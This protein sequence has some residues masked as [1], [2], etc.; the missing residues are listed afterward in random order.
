MYDKELIQQ[1][2][3][4][5]VQIRKADQQVRRLKYMVVVLRSDLTSPN[6]GLK[7]I[8]VSSS[9]NPRR[10]EDK[11]ISVIDRERQI[12]T[13][14][15]ELSAL[16]REAQRRIKRIPNPDQQRVLVARYLQNQQLEEIAADFNFPLWQIH[17]IHKEGLLAFAE[18]NRD[19]LKDAP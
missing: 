12:D 19:V 7:Q 11:I 10:F 13:L 15:R 6:C 3:N 2:Q 17:R 5:F 4:Y 1:V 18:H 9:S 16:R 14:I 8:Q